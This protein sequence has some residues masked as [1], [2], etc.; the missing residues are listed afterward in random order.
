MKEKGYSQRQACKLVGIKLKS[1]RYVS[2][3]PDDGAVRARLHV[4]AR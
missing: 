4:L 1:C 2:W 3:Q